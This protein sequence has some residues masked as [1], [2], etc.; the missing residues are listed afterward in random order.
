MRLSANGALNSANSLPTTFGIKS[1]IPAIRGSSMSCLSPSMAN[2]I[3]SGGPLTKMMMLL[4]ILMQK[5]RDKRAAKRFFRKLLNGLRYAPRRIV[6]DKLRSYGAARKEVLPDVIHS[7]GRWQNNRTE[8][9]SQPTRQRQMWRFTGL[10]TALRQIN[11]GLFR[12]IVST[13]MSNQLPVG[14]I[15]KKSCFDYRDGLSN[16][17]I[18]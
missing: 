10:S 4:G 7:N 12:G 14:K 2:V 17:L 3:I 16:T 13:S 11:E 5:H 15:V 6:T 8:V 18:Q 9:F 1:D